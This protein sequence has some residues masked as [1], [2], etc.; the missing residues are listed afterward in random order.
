MSESQLEAVGVARVAGALTVLSELVVV[1][2]VLWVFADDVVM[3]GAGALW[4]LVS[5]PV[6]YVALAKAFRESV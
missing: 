3:V 2:V 4:V 6:M 5:A 1:A